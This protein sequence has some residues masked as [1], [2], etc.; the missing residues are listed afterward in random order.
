MGKTSDQAKGNGST[1]L[2]AST[3]VSLGLFIPVL[4]LIIG[5]VAAWYDLKS[6]IRDAMSDSWKK[7]DDQI[8]MAQF[9]Q[10][11][12]L[13]MPSHVRYDDGGKSTD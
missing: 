13:T 4:A 9:S 1:T 6:D 7:V 2:S 3:K 12:N 10:E 5:G 8:F 11:N